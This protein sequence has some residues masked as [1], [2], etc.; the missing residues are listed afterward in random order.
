LK[1]TVYVIL[2][3]SLHRKWWR[4]TDGFCGVFRCQT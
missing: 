2:K 3:L 4:I 1:D